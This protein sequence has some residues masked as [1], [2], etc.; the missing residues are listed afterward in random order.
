MRSRLSSDGRVTIPK[1]VC[2]SMGLV[3]GDEVTFEITAGDAVILCRVDAD[4]AYRLAVSGTPG[5]WGSEAD[6]VAFRNL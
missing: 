6:N 1:E 2:E 3:T 4:A 5:E